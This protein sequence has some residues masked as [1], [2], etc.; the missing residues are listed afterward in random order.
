MTMA[1][2]WPRRIVSGFSS[3]SPALTY[4]DHA[5]PAA[6]VSDSPSC[7]PPS[8][9]MAAPFVARQRRSVEPGSSSRCRRVK[10]QDPIRVR[11]LQAQRDGGADLR[12]MND[13]ER[14]RLDDPEWK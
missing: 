6:S 3:A 14:A 9:V 2:G 12:G 1:A 8:S 7:V 4:R 10:P 5:T 11:K 13:A